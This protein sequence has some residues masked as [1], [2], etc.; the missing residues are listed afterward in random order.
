MLDVMTMR[1]MKKEDL[2]MMF[3]FMRWPPRCTTRV[4][5]TRPIA[6]PFLERAREDWD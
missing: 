6:S 4:L 1:E 3:T 5:R 2:E